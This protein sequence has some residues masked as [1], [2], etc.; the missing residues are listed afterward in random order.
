MN[1][2]FGTD[3]IR[4]LANRYPMNAELAF[5]LGRAVGYYNRNKKS[6]NI[7][8]GKDTRISG[9]M[10]ESAITAGLCSS[11]SNVLD[12]GI[13][14]T[15]AVGYL[16]KYY[17]VNM[18]VVISAS[19]NPYYDNG[20]KLFKNDGFKLDKRSEKKIEEILFYEK[21]KK[22]QNTGR[23]IGKV[24]PLKEA[25]E[26][27]LNYIFNTIPRDFKRPEYKIVFDCA[28]GS[29][30]LIISEL[31]SRL[32]MNF[33]TI[34]DTPD[35]ININQKCGSTYINN[36]RKAVLK[37]KADLGLAYDGDADRVLAVDEKGGLI[38]GDQIMVIYA[39]AFIKEGR[40]GNKIVVTTHMSNLGFDETINKIGGTVVR[41]NIGD[42]YV[43]RKMLELNSLLGGE[44]SGHIIFLQYSPNG[45]G[46]LTTFQL[47]DALN[48]NNEQI[49]VQA[50]KMK[51]YYQKLINYKI[52]NKKYLLQ[53]EKF[54]RINEE[55][56]KYLK[57]E[58]RILIRFSGTENKIRILLESKKKKTITKCQKAI[59]EYFTG[60]PNYSKNIL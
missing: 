12:A 59:D 36:L 50:G 28:N 15:P 48:K 13:I 16:T 21:Y 49:S 18:G 2:L 24:I 4:G 54:K 8:I 53:D 27:Y 25:R 22:I 3:G 33:I 17:Q 31:F 46:I 57:K 20:I 42:K 30:S 39:K 5:N 9:D 7:L 6:K 11:G 14:T 34:N 55:I 23:N 43:L 35:G 41:T 29:S 56:K 38:D 60:L 32:N 1:K 45:D 47:L 40:L 37:E 58:G 51:K 26:I 19:H 52:Y 10:I 44:Q